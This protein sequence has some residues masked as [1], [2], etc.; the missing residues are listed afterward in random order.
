MRLDDRQPEDQ[1]DPWG[2]HGTDPW[3]FCVRLLGA[4]YAFAAGLATEVIRLG[5]LTRLPGAPSFLPGIFQ[6]RGEVLP[7]LDVAQLLGE[8]PTPLASG[9]R[10]ALVQSGPYRLALVTEAVEGMAQIADELLEEAPQ[11]SGGILEFVDKVGRDPQ[12]PIAILDLA[13]LIDSARE[14]SV[15]S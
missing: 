4:R 14:R 12:G 7:I 5:P 11:G 6:H 10:A 8:P 9:A 13:R 15:A 1:L 2:V 3:Y